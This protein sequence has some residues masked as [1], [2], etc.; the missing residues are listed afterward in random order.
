MDAKRQ[1]VNDGSNPSLDLSLSC[2]F[3][4]K[5][6]LT[7]EGCIKLKY[8]DIC[9]GQNIIQLRI[10]CT[11]G[12]VTKCHSKLFMNM[13]AF[14]GGTSFVDILWF[15][16]L[17]CFAMPFYA[18]VYLCLVITCWERADLLALVCGV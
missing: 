2:A 16:F 18:S 15:F 10:K 7:V 5:R 3:G 1:R 17:S 12:I 11:I 8:L 4:I 6:Q 14:R 9:I 13:E